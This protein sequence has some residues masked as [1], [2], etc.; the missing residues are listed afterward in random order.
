MLLIL[1]SLKKFI[2][3]SSRVIDNYIYR[4]HYKVTVLI[5]IVF[6]L[7]V[8]ADQ[9]F[10]DPIHC[11]GSK[12]IPEKL[13]DT[14]CWIQTTFSIESAWKK[15]VGTGVIYPGVPHFG[16]EKLSEEQILHHTYYQWVGL[17]LLFQAI[18]FYIPRYL[19]KETE[20]GLIKDL[21]LGLDAR[22]LNEDQK[23]KS[24]SLLVEYLHQNLNNH[25]KLFLI[26]VT[27]EALN[28]FNVI[29]QMFL[30]NKFLG[31]A[32][33][34]YGWD[35]I[36][37]SE[38]EPLLRYNPML[39]PFPRVTRC[40]IYKFGETLDV[41]S[42]HFMCILSINIL[43]EKVYIFLWF[44][45]YF[46]AIMSTLVIIYRVIIIF[47]SRARVNAIS[48]HCRNANKQELESV[49]RHCRVGDWFVINLLSKNLDSFNFKDLIHDLNG[50]MEEK[51]TDGKQ[52]CL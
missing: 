15:K 11:T 36:N 5:L 39:K 18:P 47:N 40:T 17:F 27:T 8:K 41:E 16:V 48:S 1:E 43:N 46:L 32:F 24:R 30:M 34:N 19:W 49:L 26:Y 25:N 51:S 44:W 6:S 31:G 10:G 21:I 45:F 4:L 22:F 12:E 28:L 52:V 23:E 50:R 9:Y 38:W 20:N 3:P 29:S 42:R 7:L 33:I 14:Y 35:V 13:V 37:L 2:K